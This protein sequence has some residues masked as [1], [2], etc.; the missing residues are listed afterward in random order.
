MATR[1]ASCRG[2]L[3]F[4]VRKAVLY[5]GDIAQTRQKAQIVPWRELRFADCGLRISVGLI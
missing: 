5:G 2:Q 1:F 3:G 4:A